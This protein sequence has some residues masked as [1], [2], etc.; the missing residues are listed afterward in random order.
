MTGLRGGLT[1]AAELRVLTP[2][3]SFSSWI[4][5]LARLYSTMAERQAMGKRAGAK[6]N[7]YAVTGHVLRVLGLPD[8]GQSLR[9]APRDPPVGP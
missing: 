7:Q 3:S 9:A 2:C 6:R 8:V 5:G 4:A 1:E